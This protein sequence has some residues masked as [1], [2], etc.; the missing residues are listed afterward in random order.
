M[1]CFYIQILPK[2]IVPTQDVL[3]TLLILMLI[4]SVVSIHQYSPLRSPLSTLSSAFCSV[5]A[6]IGYSPKLGKQLSKWMD[7]WMNQFWNTYLR[8]DC[9]SGKG[10]LDWD[11]SSRFYFTSVQLSNFKPCCSGHA[12]TEGKAWILDSSPKG[13]WKSDERSMKQL[14]KNWYSSYQ[15]F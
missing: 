10:V 2:F 13:E 5:S 6:G 8:S 3:I 9:S 7:G 12:L 1:C 4:T 11:A 15:W 14:I